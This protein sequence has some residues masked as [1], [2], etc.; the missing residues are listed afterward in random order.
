MSTYMMEFKVTFVAVLQ[1]HCI[2][3]GRGLE[4]DLLVVEKVR[5][6][7]VGRATSGYCDYLSHH[8]WR[9]G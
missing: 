3:N 6:G 5:G 1:R 8:G 4:D 9:G 7:S 2:E